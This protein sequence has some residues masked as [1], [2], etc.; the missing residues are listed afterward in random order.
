MNQDSR[1]LL[2]VVICGDF[3]VN[4][5]S[6]KLVSNRLFHE[7]GTLAVDLNYGNNR[8]IY[9]KGLE[10]RNKVKAEFESACGELNI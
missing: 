10:V 7:N 3:K 4:D 2:D 1:L 9:E 8:A 6:D 5:N